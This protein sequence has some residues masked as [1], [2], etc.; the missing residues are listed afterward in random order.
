MPTFNALDNANIIPTMIARG[1]LE[2]AKPNL[3]FAKMCR[4][5]FE[6][7]AQQKGDTVTI[8]RFGKPT[9]IDKTAGT[10]IAARQGLATST[11]DVKLDKHKIIPLTVEDT[12]RAFSSPAAW[13]EI[14]TSAALA[15]AEAVETSVWDLIPTHGA[16]DPTY[17][18]G[19]YGTSID[20]ALILDI[21]DAFSAAKIPQGFNKHCILS[22]EGISNIMNIDAFTT[23][24]N[25]GNVGGQAPVITGKLPA[26]YGTNFYESQIA[27][28]VSGSPTQRSGVSFITP[29][30]AIVSRPIKDPMTEGLMNEV[31][32]TDVYVDPDV[33]ISVRVTVGYD[34]NNVGLMVNIDVLFG[35]K[36]VQPEWCWEIRH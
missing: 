10:P 6:K 15:L 13:N 3:M 28:I 20:K 25:V 21:R 34:M 27:P 17:N 7:E 2:R 31:V 18:L 30:I 4:R 35:V 24:I 11:V 36:I 5:D 1:V 12:A 16:A 19:S 22:V 29:A 26:L 14:M 9:V 8:T 32:K 23:A 33:N